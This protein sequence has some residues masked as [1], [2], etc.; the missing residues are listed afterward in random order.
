[1]A[2]LFMVI[3]AFLLGPLWGL[4]LDYE[5]GQQFQLIQM[6]TPLFISYISTAVTYATLGRSFPEPRGQRGRI[7]RAVTFGSFALFMI[8]MIAATGMYYVSAR[9]YLLYGHLD[10]D[11]YNAAVTG[12]LAFLAAVTSAISTF[13]FAVER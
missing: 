7:L 12:L 4:R 2:I 1:M 5:K 6:I 8:G 3:L 13:I 9:G 10:F 11:H